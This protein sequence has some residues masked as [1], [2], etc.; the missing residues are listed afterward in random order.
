MDKTAKDIQQSIE[1]QVGLLIIKK[2]QIMK[3]Q[4]LW[5]VTAVLCT[6]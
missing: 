3:V 4:M 2:S 1:E 5:A 6:N